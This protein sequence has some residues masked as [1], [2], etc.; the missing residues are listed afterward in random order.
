MPEKGGVIFDV[1]WATKNSQVRFYIVLQSLWQYS[2]SP[3]VAVMTGGEELWLCI[4][5][6]SM[7]TKKNIFVVWVMVAERVSAQGL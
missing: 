6:E 7:E 5:R 4:A 1:E 3:T 2:H